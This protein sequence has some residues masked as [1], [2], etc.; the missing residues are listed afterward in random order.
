MLSISEKLIIL[1]I[2]LSSQIFPGNNIIFIT[3]ISIASLIIILTYYVRFNKY[4]LPIYSCI[5]VF[6]L[7][8][9]LVFQFDD[10][11]SFIRQFS[12]LIYPWLLLFLFNLLILKNANKESKIL[13]ILNFTSF[14]I[15]IILLPDFISLI[16][17]LISNPN[18][19]ILLKLSSII[20]RETNTTAFLLLYAIIFRIEN[21]LSNFRELSIASFFLLL[22]FSRSAILLFFVYLIYKYSNKLFHRFKLI[23]FKLL[24]S[25]L[26]PF[27][28][29][30]AMLIIW[31]TTTVTLENLGGYSISLSDRS[32]FTRI[33]L[34]SYIKY[35]L[36][37]IDLS[38]MIN[39]LF[40]YGWSAYQNILID[41]P[42]D[43]EGG[44]TGHT[45]IGILPEYGFIYTC[46]LFLFFYIRAFR[47]F[48]AD[49][50]LLGLS[51]LAFFP[52]PYIAP[53]I[54]L[55]QTHRKLNVAIN[56]NL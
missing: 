46:F 18:N 33:L 42:F 3:Y 39:F 5:L 2:T 47:G 51:I 54:C 22:T 37:T 10:L 36:S 30:G 13:S 34:F 26:F 20:Y 35:Y 50:I 28:V 19:L 23:N 7:I 45:L 8:I 6:F 15:Y 44:T 49:T 38:E 40:G 1:L 12:R 17:T 32:F 27:A 43:Y 24:F 29:L 52:F 48:I 25:R 56:E 21:K 16:Y 53:I 14:S 41:L 11:N 55:I 31:I 4:Q 9:A